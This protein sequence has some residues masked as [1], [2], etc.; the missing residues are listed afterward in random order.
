M[1]FH[2]AAL[3]ITFSIVEGLA[4]LV[5]LLRLM[6]RLKIGRF[7]W[8]DMWA[9]LVFVFG[10]TFIVSQLVSF[11]SAKYETEFISNWIATS[12][13][14]CA[15]WAVRMSLLYSVIRITSPLST[16]HK[17]A[18]I[19]AFLFFLCWAILIALKIWWCVDD[20]KSMLIFGSLRPMCFLP[21]QITIFE[22]ISH[23]ISVVILV[24]LSFKLLW[25]VKLPRRQR[26]MILSLFSSTLII[27][28]FS[29]F[30]A[31][32][33]LLPFKHIRFVAFELEVASTLMVCDLL[34]VV[35]YIY[36]VILSSP[37]GSLPCDSKSFSD[38]DDFTTRIPTALT[39]VD[40]DILDIT[41][42][43]TDSHVTGSNPPSLC[44]YS[45][46]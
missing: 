10:T 44:H 15:V 40:L 35:T 13:F 41:P 20:T 27:C 6:F 7:G 3:L 19:I 33:E 4:M 26:R 12:A 45:D 28:L 18:T 17:L 30:H 14:T 16:L 24:I 21:S 39:T 9:A 11:D 1:S 5:T 43:V 8:E 34:V 36:R 29:L 46:S 23:W 25:R 31:V 42:E 32:C 22:M 37:D 38:D 2:T